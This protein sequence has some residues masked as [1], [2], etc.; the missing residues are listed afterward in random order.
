VGSGEAEEGIQ[1]VDGAVGF[2]T[3][4]SLGNALAEDEAGGAVIALFGRN[5]HEDAASLVHRQ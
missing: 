5:T 4:V 3:Q 2:D 1:F